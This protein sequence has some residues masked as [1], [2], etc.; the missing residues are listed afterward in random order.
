MTLIPW[1]PIGSRKRHPRSVR[2]SIVDPLPQAV[3][4]SLVSDLPGPRQETAAERAARYDDQMAEVLSFR[5]RNCAEAMIACQ[6]VLLRV[7]AG[8]ANGVSPTQKP[9]GDAK[10]LARLIIDMKQ[11]LAD[12]QAAPLG[13]IDKSIFV[14]L[15]L[16]ESLIPD[17]G[18]PDQLNDAFSAI[19]IPL[20]AAPKMLQ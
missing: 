15:G 4:R 18:D 10:Q 7:L 12:R 3:L 17:P 16:T 20:H 5:P 6:C 2:K 1:P 11:A 8:M 9:S 13:K 14:A 19:I